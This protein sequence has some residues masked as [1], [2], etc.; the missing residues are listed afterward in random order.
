[1]LGL[2]SR[3]LAGLWVPFWVY[4]GVPKCPKTVKRNYFLVVLDYFSYTNGPDDLFRGLFSNLDIKTYILQTCGPSCTFLGPF[5]GALMPQSNIKW[6]FLIVP[7]YFSHKNR[8]IY[9][10]RGPFWSLNFGPYNRPTCGLLSIFFC[11]FGGALMPQ[12]V[13]KG[14]KV[15]RMNVPMTKLENEPLTKS[16]SPIL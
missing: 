7:D 16:I 9:L 4:L 3:S 11:P 12:N 6:V 13:H 2:T 1:M 14:P 5:G 8:P 10:V 15:G